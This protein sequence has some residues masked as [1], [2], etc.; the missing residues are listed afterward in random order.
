[1]IFLNVWHIPYSFYIVWTFFI[2]QYF[3]ISYCYDSNKEQF[4]WNLS[5]TNFTSYRKETTIS[6]QRN[7]QVQ[8]LGQNGRFSIWTVTI[9]CYLAAGP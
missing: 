7:L 6:D 4:I 8:I 5:L 1:M 3:V 9:T 2:E